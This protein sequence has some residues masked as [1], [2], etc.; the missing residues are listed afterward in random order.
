MMFERLPGAAVCDA[1]SRAAV[2]SNNIPNGSQ[3]KLMM[4]HYIRLLGS[5]LGLAALASAARGQAPD[6]LIVTIPYEFVV[7][8]KTLPAGTYRVNRISDWDQKE[9][10]IS[11]FENHVAVLVV[12]SEIEVSSDEEPGVSFQQAGNQHFLNKIETAAH[13][14]TI[15]VTTAPNAQL[16]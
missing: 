9:L 15:P 8:G 2:I 1:N 4:R 3:E 11:S 6:Q 14:F 13:I 10:M 16:R 7:A 12:S 5:F